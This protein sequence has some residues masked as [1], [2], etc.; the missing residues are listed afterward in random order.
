MQSA[1]NVVWIVTTQWRAQATGYAGDPNVRTPHL[2]RLARASV[3][4][5][6]AVTPHPFG[7]FARAAMLTGRQSPENGVIDYF[8]PLPSTTSTI[9]HDLAARGYET[10]FFGK[11]HLGKRDASAPIVGETHAKMIIPPGDRGGFEFWEGFESG[12]LL[13]DPWLHGSRLQTPTQIF[14]YQSDVLC[15]RAGTFIAKRNASIGR[16]PAIGVSAPVRPLFAVVSLEAPHPPYAAASA[17]SVPP[18]LNHLSLRANVPV[19]GEIEAKAR[20]DLAGYSAHIEATDR[21][22]G[23]LL[24]ATSLSN[25]VVVFTSVH[26]DMHGSH[27]L[28]RKGWPYEESIRVPLLVRFP[29]P[30]GVGSSDDDTAISLLDLPEMTR[31]WA[32]GNPSPPRPTLSFVSMP[33]AP[34][35]PLQCDRRWQGVRTPRHKMIVNADGSPWLYF[36]LEKD[37]FEQRN[38]VGDSSRADEINALKAV[39]SAG[40]VQ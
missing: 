28:F 12:F 32:D 14:G 4:F 23:V 10:A 22:I 13:N 30:A 6:Q 5:R 11:W 31:A 20:R 18:D 9:A 26:G 15:E 19:G 16:E 1:P 35:F 2:D 25:T 40:S 39:I 24:N 3:N 17:A 21:A 8:D 38:L 34:P 33:S 27:G 7:P 29:G 36:D 37:P